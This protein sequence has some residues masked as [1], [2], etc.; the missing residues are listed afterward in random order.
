MHYFL[1]RISQDEER[2]GEL[3]M[4]FR[5]ARRDKERQTIA[6]DYS[7]TVQ[8]LIDGGGWREMPAPEDQLPDAWM[9]SAF[10]EDW[11]RRQGDPQSEKGS[12]IGALSVVA[13]RRPFLR[14][15]ILRA[16]CP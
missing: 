16:N 14:T 4:K 6:E 9:P 3:A 8:H 11:S 2:L 13:N 1:P 15:A 10:I 12:K 5:G 7:Q